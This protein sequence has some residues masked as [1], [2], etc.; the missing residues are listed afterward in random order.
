[1]SDNFEK[2]ENYAGEHVDVLGATYEEGKPTG[3][4]IGRWA[5]KL[6]D[7]DDILYYLRTAERYWYGQ[8]G[9]KS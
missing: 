3:K 9:E 7:K 8:E 6:E 4:G 2:K 5:H 1:M